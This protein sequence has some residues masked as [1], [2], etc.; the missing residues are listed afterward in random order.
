MFLLGFHD[1]YVPS[2]E[3]LFEVA[4]TYNSSKSMHRDLPYIHWRSENNKVMSYD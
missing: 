4:S 2:V 1:G 3:K